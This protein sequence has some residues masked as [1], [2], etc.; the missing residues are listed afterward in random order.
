MEVP[1]VLGKI[2]LNARDTTGSPFSENLGYTDINVLNPSTADTL[3]AV[4]QSFP[5]NIAALTTGTYIKGTVT[6]EVDLSQ[7]EVGE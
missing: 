3:A 5:E 4:L 1:D 2:T 6:Y 7:L